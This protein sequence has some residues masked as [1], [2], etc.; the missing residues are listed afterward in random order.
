MIVDRQLS[1]ALNE[2]QRMFAGYRRTKT[3]PTDR[4]LVAFERVMKVLSD[5]S[6]ELETEITRLR[7]GAVD[8]F[9]RDTD[10]LLAEVRRPGSNV[11]L[12]RIVPRPHYGGAA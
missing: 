10:A 4:E 7:F 2:I 6:Y 8:R 9:E 3:G 5:R 12:F 11:T 1:D